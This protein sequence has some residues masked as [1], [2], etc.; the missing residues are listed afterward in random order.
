MFLFD[1][2][3]TR[4]GAWARTAARLQVDCHGTWTPLHWRGQLLLQAVALAPFLIA[5]VVLGASTSSGASI[6]PV[7][8]CSPAADTA[9]IATIGALALGCYVAPQLAAALWLARLRETRYLRLE[10]FGGAATSVVCLT[11]L[12]AVY[13]SRLPSSAVTAPAYTAEGEFQTVYLQSVVQ[14]A[15]I[16]TLSAMIAGFPP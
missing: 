6:G 16:A 9:Y 10:V 12:C 13:G 4:P 11:A 8:T 7:S 1:R 2:A 15:S 5:A 3:A 14:S